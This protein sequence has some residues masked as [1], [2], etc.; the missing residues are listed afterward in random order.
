MSISRNP[1]IAHFA[2][3]VQGAKIIRV[4]GKDSIFIKKFSENI[5]KYLKQIK[6]TNLYINLFSL[7]M[8]ILNISLLLLTGILGIWLVQNKYITVGS[9]GVAF[10][11]IFINGY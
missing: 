7:Q 5:E 1:A 3:T 8:S 9:L 10:T 6:I 11:F 4:F 2:E